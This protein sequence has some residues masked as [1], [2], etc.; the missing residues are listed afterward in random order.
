VWQ[1]LRIRHDEGPAWCERRPAVVAPGAVLY[2]N[3]VTAATATLVNDRLLLP[4]DAT[5]IIAA[6]A[7]SNG[8]G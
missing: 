1:L 4:A 2:V 7:A 3:L 5:N 8:L 6:A